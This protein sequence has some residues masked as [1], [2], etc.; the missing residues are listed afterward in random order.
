MELRCRETLLKLIK[1][2]NI[3]KILVLST[4][5]IESIKTKKIIRNNSTAKKE[6]LNSI[7][8]LRC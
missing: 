1:A 2:R 8:N 3:I 7:K 4:S 5:E 6:F